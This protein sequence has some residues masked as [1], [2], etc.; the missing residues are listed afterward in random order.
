MA[1]TLSVADYGASDIY[2]FCRTVA[3]RYWAIVGEI[4]TKWPEM[5]GKRP[6]K[7]IER[8]PAKYQ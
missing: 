7:T 6:I 4:S 2:R 3:V 8:P 1:E 5:T